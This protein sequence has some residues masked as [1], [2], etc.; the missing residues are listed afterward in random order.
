[1]NLQYFQ[2][3]QLNPSF[4]TNFL[5]SVLRGTNLDHIDLND[6]MKSSETILWKYRKR[7]QQVLVA[8]EF[9]DWAS[10]AKSCKL[11]IQ[12]HTWKDDIRAGQAM[13]W[14]SATFAQV[15]RTRDR[16][17]SLAFFCGKHVELEDAPVGGTALISSLV[18]QLLQQHYAPT[19]FSQ[20]DI[21]LESLRAGDI[22]TLCHLF[23]W[24]VR[25]LA[26]DKTVMCVIDSV[27][28]YETSELENNMR[29][30]LRHLLDL[31][32]DKDVPAAFR[33]LL[34]S[35]TGTIGV[36]EEYQSEDAN[37]LFIESLQ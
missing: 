30:V 37:I 28:A 3:T 2:A 26:R 29:R 16:F 19:T 8:K 7:T 18:A 9:Y 11:L 24:L 12:G 15:T 23:A 14:V 10:P 32:E 21:D 1:M 31:A 36:H 33:V 6:I 35:V 13:A 34:T 25:Q 5:P 27:D 17:I 22:R 20:Q 4:S